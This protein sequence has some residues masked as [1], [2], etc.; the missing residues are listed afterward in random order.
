LQRVEKCGV[1]E[2]LLL[3][4]YG[5]MKTIFK[6]ALG[7]VLLGFGF[8]LSTLGTPPSSQAASGDITSE[9]TAT[10]FVNVSLGSPDASRKLGPVTI[11]VTK[12]EVTTKQDGKPIYSETWSADVPPPESAFF[13]FDKAVNGERQTTFQRPSGYT[14]TR[15]N[16][17]WI[18]GVLS[19]KEKLIPFSPDSLV[20]SFGS[21]SSFQNEVGKNT[22][23]YGN[24]AD[25]NRSLDIC[26]SGSGAYGFRIARDDE[27]EFGFGS[28]IPRKWIVTG[29]IL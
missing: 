15:F 16:S 23:A 6:F 13:L 5:Y 19:L 10:E 17:S 4:N 24:N 3:R 27:N 29:T 2:V 20:F 8:Y 12:W 18:F 21:P 14:D 1:D 9:W 26:I 11:G 7:L 22:T 25:C 28:I